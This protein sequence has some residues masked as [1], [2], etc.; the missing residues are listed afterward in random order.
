MSEFE[1]YYNLFKD[2]TGNNKDLW[3]TLKETIPITILPAE[4]IMGS[5]T[6]IL[7]SLYQYLTSFCKH[8]PAAC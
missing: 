6:P 4:L 8:W 7:P 3:K 5:P 1:Y 2:S